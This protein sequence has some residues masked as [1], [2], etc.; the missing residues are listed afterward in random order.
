MTGFATRL[1]S[2]G[3]MHPSL[4]L[5]AGESVDGGRL[6]WRFW[7]AR[8]S[9]ASRRLR[10]P[11]PAGV[12]SAASAATLRQEVEPVQEAVLD[13]GDRSRCSL[14]LPR[15][16]ISSIKQVTRQRRS[17]EQDYRNVMDHVITY[18]R[19]IGLT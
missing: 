11:G 6:E 4:G 7:C 13:H 8:A 16:V 10:K 3:G 19:H 1:A 17:V 9:N 18:Y 12:H 2:L 5:F 14:L 15:G